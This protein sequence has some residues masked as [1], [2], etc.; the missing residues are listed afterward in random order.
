MGVI[1]RMGGG[2]A[3][4]GRVRRRMRRRIT[5]LTWRRVR[6]VREWM[7]VNNGERGFGVFTGEGHWSVGFVISA[8]FWSLWVLLCTAGGAVAFGG[9]RSKRESK[10]DRRSFRKAAW[11]LWGFA[12]VGAAAFLVFHWPPFNSE[13]HRYAR[14]QGV[15]SSVD[16]RLLGDGKSTTQNYAV[17]FRESPDLTFRCD[18]TRCASVHAG[19]TLSLDCKRAFQWN[20]SNPGYVCNFAAV[21][22]AGRR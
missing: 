19:D 17:V 13:Y 20:S 6:G 1:R 2:V 18:D 11:V 15:V 7:M 21:S 3:G 12:L 5:G 4:V 14:V 9:S 16:S 22:R 10:R 8:V